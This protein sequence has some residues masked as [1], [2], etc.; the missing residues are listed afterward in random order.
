MLNTLI[1][2]S[3]SEKDL[4]VL[5]EKLPYVKVCELICRDYDHPLKSE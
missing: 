1:V 5:R 2:D 4:N 3:I